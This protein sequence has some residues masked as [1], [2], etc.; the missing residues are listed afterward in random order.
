MAKRI[1]E[2]ALRKVGDGKIISP[3]EA[4][5]RGMSNPF[6]FIK[7]ENIMTNDWTVQ[8]ELLRID[9]NKAIESLTKS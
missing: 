9:T 7:N 8:V 2:N 6:E 3:T 4:V 5:F 1:K